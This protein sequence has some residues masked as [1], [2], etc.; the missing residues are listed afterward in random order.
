MRCSLSRIYAA[1]ELV[2]IFARFRGGSESPGAFVLND[3]DVRPEVVVHWY[4]HLSGTPLSTS[5]ETG[6]EH[7]GVLS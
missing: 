2:V 4:M 3:V 7:H 5:Y 6:R 1:P